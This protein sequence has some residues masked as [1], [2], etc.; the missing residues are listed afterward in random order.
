MEKIKIDLEVD[1]LNIDELIQ[2]AEKLKNLLLEVNQ[3]FDSLKTNQDSKNLNRLPKVI[4]D[5]EG[6]KVKFP[7]KIEIKI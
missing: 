1:T 6:L 4:F 7:K 2:K 5:S 3:L